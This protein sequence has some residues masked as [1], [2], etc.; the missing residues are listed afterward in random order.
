M[1]VIF[2]EMTGMA[3]NP[4]ILLTPVLNYTPI[5]IIFKNKTNAIH[6]AKINLNSIY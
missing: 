4:N 3:A 1:T 6:A 5:F 2:D